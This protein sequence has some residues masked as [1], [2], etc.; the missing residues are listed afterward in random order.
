MAWVGAAVAVLTAVAISPV[1]AE[2]GPRYYLF[3]GVISMMSVSGLFFV[4]TPFSSK[5]ATVV[6][7]FILY[8]MV[9]VFFDKPSFSVLFLFFFFFSQ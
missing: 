8:V 4:L 6:Y 2:V 3:T 7:S 5:S 1:W 9:T